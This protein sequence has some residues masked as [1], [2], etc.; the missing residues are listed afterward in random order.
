MLYAFDTYTLD[1]AQYE[2]RQAG[3]LISLEPRVFDLLAYLVRHPGRIVT[4][5]ELLEQLY[6][7]Q[8]APVDRL[9][10]AVAQARRALGDTSQTQRDIQTVRR[11]GYR[12]IASAAIRQQTEMDAQS[13]PV[14][15]PMPTE[16]YRLDQDDTGSPP[17]PSV[18]SPLPSVPLSA[19][20]PASAPRAIR[21]FT[22]EAERRQLTVLV[23]RLVGISERAKRLDPEE[24]LEVVRDY[25]AIG[26]EVVRRFDGHIAQYQEDRL[27]VYF[28]YPQAHEDDARRAVHAGL[29]LVEKMAE[30]NKRRPR[31]G[32]VQLAMRVGIHTGVVVLGA[33]GQDE[34]ALLALGDTP[35]I[36]AQVQGLAAPDTVVIGPTT[37]RL[38]EGYFVTQAFSARLHAED[39]ELVAVYRVL[40][41]S[42]AQSRLDVV[43]TTGLTPFVGREHE[44]GLLHDRWQ[45]ATSGMGQVVVLSGE[46]GIGKSRVIQV[47]K[48]SLAGE[49]YTEIECYC[50]PYYQHTAFYPMVTAVQRLLLFSPEDTP[51][52]KLIKLE[53][54][55]E[56]YGFE[57]EEVVPL[58][59]TLLSLT[60]PE[61]YPSLPLTPEQ[62]KQKTLETLLTWLLKEAERQPVCMIMEDLHWGDASTLEWLGLLL[63]QVPT[64]C[65]LLLLLC[66]P[67]FHPPWAPRAHLTPITLRNLGRA[68]VEAMAKHVAGGKTLPAGLITQI[69]EKTDGVP[70]FVEE[71]TKAIVESNV[72]RDV[73]DYYALTEPVEAVRIPVTLHDALM[74]RLDRL[75]TAKSL[76]QLGAVIGRR[77]SYDLVKALTA[78]DEGRL[79]QELGQLVNAELLYQR[80]LPPHA[81]YMFK[82]ALIQ[83]VAYESLLR[84]RRQALHRAI[85]EAI[86]ALEGERVAAQAGILAYH[87]ARSL[88]QDK[89]VTYALLAGDEAVRLL[90][91]TEATTHYLQA[92]TLARGLPNAPEAQRMQIDAILKLAAISSSREGLARD[93][94]NLE[95]ALALAEILQDQPR[96]ARV[97]Y[98]QGR[99]AYVRGDLRAAITYAEQS[100][101]IADHSEDETLSA[102]PVNLL[103][104]SYTMWWDVARGSQLMVRSTAQMHHIGNRVEEATAA[105]FAAMA[106]GALGEFAQALAYGDRGIALAQESANPFAEA[107]A[108]FYRGVAYTHQGAW[109]QAMADFDA[110]R[111]VAA[112][113]GDHFRVYVVNLYAGWAS[114]RAGNPAAGR[115]LLEQAF[116]IAEQIGTVFHV[117]LGKA[118]LAVCALALGELDTVPALCQEALRVAEETSDR[119]AQAVAHRALAEALTLAIAPDRQQAEHAM[120]EAIQLWKEI[121][122]NPELARTYVSYAHLLQGWGQDGQAKAYL[123]EAIAMFQEIGMDWDL[124]QV[125]VLA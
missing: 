116:T 21:P 67:E 115:V 62:Q 42:P 38:V 51:A 11:R 82:H 57:L 124:T 47:L 40:Q 26:A 104:R 28:G 33:M 49:A 84:R 81:T 110:A 75:H 70:L 35:T 106:F 65:M 43:V 58:W 12:F 90:A 78:Y 23:C 119:F 95:Q 80:G 6:P 29:G 92:L 18:Q 109:T 103:G 54:M 46:A 107:A 63:D 83:D 34:H 85:A 17:P 24:L 66:R 2:L 94:A 19:P 121:E 45:Q 87:Y 76:A 25:H 123:T 74:A 89:A 20:D 64:A 16:R 27:V 61:G 41:A 96:L 13:P 14:V 15:P 114:T 71:M 125:G 68:H 9:T 99:L 113:V 30:L 60:L 3:R 55:L 1:L 97:L 105:G 98:W 79:Q 112:G 5:E 37:L 31:A 22:P 44:I 52:A 10:N 72:L 69:A 100:L 53:D 36:A 122:F 111:Q 88:R 77:F 7:N 32:D 118:W 86:E 117:A 59:T 50:S 102:P 120:G 101:A 73:G 56:R 48:A 4:T 91:R 93:Q 108:L 39:T 8:F